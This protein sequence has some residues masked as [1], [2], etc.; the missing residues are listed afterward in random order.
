MTLLCNEDGT[1]II[2]LFCNCTFGDKALYSDSGMNSQIPLANLLRFFRALFY[3]GGNSLSAKTRNHSWQKIMHFKNSLTYIPKLTASIVFF[4][5]STGAAKSFREISTQG[6]FKF[7][8]QTPRK[9]MN[10]YMQRLKQIKQDLH[11]E[12]FP[13]GVWLFSFLFLLSFFFFFLSEEQVCNHLTKNKIPTA[14][15]KNAYLES[16]YLRKK[17]SSQDMFHGNIV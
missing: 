17:L 15:G 16:E 3:E 1:W 6:C 13:L 5:H 4:P 12:S 11:F 14:S 2:T 8:K 9:Y 7:E 10:L